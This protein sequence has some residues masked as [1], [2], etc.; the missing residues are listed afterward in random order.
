MSSTGRRLGLLPPGRPQRGGGARIPSSPGD[1]PTAGSLRRAELGAV[2]AA[3]ARRAQASLPARLGLG[4]HPLPAPEEAVEAHRRALGGGPSAPSSTSHRHG[5]LLQLVGARALRAVGVDS[6]HAMLAVARANGK[7]RPGGRRTAPGR[8]HA[9]PVG[10]MPS[11]WCW[12]T[13][14]ALPRC[15][16]RA[17]REARRRW[18]RAGGSGG[19]F[20]AHERFCA[21]PWP[22]PPWLRPRTGGRLVRRSRPDVVVGDR[23][24]PRTEARRAHRVALA[25]P[26]SRV[27][28][29]WRAPAA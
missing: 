22:S 10:A 16:A 3:R 14:A 12:C 13:G 7:G 2:R 15:P 23:R 26:G 11:T 19:G 6:S 20:A 4:P 25:R 1:W 9:L 8:H 27:V 29:D 21:T 17:I 5:A 24:R 18:R 28:T